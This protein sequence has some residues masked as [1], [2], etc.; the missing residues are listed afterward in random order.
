MQGG[1]V[2]VCLC[3]YRWRSKAKPSAKHTQQISDVPVAVLFTLQ[4]STQR[5]AT[6]HTQHT[7]AGQCQTHLKTSNRWGWVAGASR[8]QSQDTS[9][10]CLFP[11]HR[12]PDGIQ[13]QCPLL[14][15]SVKFLLL[16]VK[17][18]FRQ[19]M[20]Q[21][22]DIITKYLIGKNYQIVENSAEIEVVH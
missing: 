21:K 14:R 7:P 8:L 16:Y 6:Q 22:C 11:V 13:I 10:G 3:A 18:C 19:N 4:H 9:C 2:A 15:F 20:P 1:P 17:L 12:L 5:Q